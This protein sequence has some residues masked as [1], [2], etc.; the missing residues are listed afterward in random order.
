LFTLLVQG[1]TIKPLLV[2]LDLLD[3]N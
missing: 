1:L 3:K 2:K